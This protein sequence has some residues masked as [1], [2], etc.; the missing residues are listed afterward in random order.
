MYDMELGVFERKDVQ[1]K[2]SADGLDCRGG[3]LVWWEVSLIV[4]QG[5]PYRAFKHLGQTLRFGTC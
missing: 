2:D 4:L 5:F 1:C 3:F